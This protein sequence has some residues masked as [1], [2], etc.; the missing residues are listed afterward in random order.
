[1]K[2]SGVLSWVKNPVKGFLMLVSG[3]IPTVQAVAHVEEE[4]ASRISE[5]M[6]GW[7]HWGMAGGWM[8]IFPVLVGTLLIISIALIVRTKDTPLTIH[9]EGK[10]KRG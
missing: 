3:L 1:M 9:Q 7:T 4:T 8:L 2:V 5:A 6:D 10:G